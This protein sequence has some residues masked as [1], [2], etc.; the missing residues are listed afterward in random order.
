LSISAD[1]G[2]LGRWNHEFDGFFAFS[3]EQFGT[4]RKLDILRNRR[5]SASPIKL[6]SNIREH[7]SRYGPDDL[8]LKLSRRISRLDSPFRSSETVSI[9]KRSQDN[10]TVQI[11]SWLFQR[12]K[13]AGQLRNNR[14]CRRKIAEVD[15]TMENLN[16][17]DQLEDLMICHDDTSDKSTDT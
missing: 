12:G 1:R 8:K 7:G 5:F 11:I 6:H 17:G 15:K 16:L 9:G 4:R 13:L 3:Q 10:C 14:N 2:E